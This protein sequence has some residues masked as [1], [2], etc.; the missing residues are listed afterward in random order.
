MCLI[1]L[2]HTLLHWLFLAVTS[3]A[4]GK[5]SSTVLN[6]LQ[7]LISNAEALGAPREAIDRVAGHRSSNTLEE[8]IAFPLQPELSKPKARRLTRGPSKD[9]ERGDRLRRGLAILLAD[10][11][12]GSNFGGALVEGS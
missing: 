6:L 2:S 7:R 1:H 12:S 11:G 8:A 4:F 9:T 3:I 10:L 5:T